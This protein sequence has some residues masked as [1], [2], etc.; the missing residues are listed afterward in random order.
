MSESNKDK[1]KAFIEAKKHKQKEQEK[2]IPN[3][4]MGNS[5]GGS[6]NLKTGGSNNK[7]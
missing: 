1:M 2:I 4:K 7:V 3:R 5:R 6:N